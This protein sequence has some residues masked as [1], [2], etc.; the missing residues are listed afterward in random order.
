MLT[1]DGLHGRLA[2]HR[3]IWARTQVLVWGRGKPLE[4]EE[5]LNII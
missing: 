4:A 3:G 1:V 5:H 2:V